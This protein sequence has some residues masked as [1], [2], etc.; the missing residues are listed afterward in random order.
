MRAAGT[1]VWGA[2]AALQALGACALDDRSPE[3]VS[4]NSPAADA[5]AG[6]VSAG[7]GSGA[8]SNG[9]GA[10][11]S[12]SAG[13]LSAAGAG[14]TEGGSGPVDSIGTDDLD[15]LFSDG[16]NVS[17]GQTCSS[18]A[19]CGGELEGTWSYSDVCI[20]PADTSIGLLQGVCPDATLQFER[21]S[22]STLTFSNARVTRTGVP[23]GDSVIT[24]PSECTADLGGCE[25]LAA[26]LDDAAV[27]EDLNGDCSCHTPAS[28][29]WGTPA[30]SVEGGQ[31]L[32]DDGRSIDY[33]VQG[34]QLTYRETGEAAESG[35]Y[36]LQRN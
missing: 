35:T 25:V 9:G 6:G 23:L 12:G 15:D 24:F 27:C 28:S 19:A 32:L 5:G 30:Y 33:C 7:R 16:S 13:T 20:E 2:I 18:W 21:Q 17:V 36:T 4:S 26:L 1:S 34:D 22:G 8:A 29:D 14:G 11:I 10:G 3:L 31:L